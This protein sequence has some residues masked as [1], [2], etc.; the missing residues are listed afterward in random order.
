MKKFIIFL[1]VLT[2]LLVLPSPSK[3]VSQ[4]FRRIKTIPSIDK[5]VEVTSSLGW[6]EKDAQ[7]LLELTRRENKPI[8]NLL[9]S[10]I[11]A[12][13]ILNPK[14][15]LTGVPEP[16]HLPYGIGGVYPINDWD[17]I[18]QAIKQLDPQNVKLLKVG[19]QNDEKGGTLWEIP[20]PEEMNPAEEEL[21]ARY[22]AHRIVNHL[23][24]YG[25]EKVMLSDSE[26][27]QKIKK[28]F[29]PLRG[30]DVTLKF[31][32][33][34]IEEQVFAPDAS[35]ISGQFLDF[36][37]GLAEE[38]FRKIKQVL[39][40]TYSGKFVELLASALRQD[41]RYS[42]IR[43]I[44]R[45]NN[46]DLVMDKFFENYYGQELPIVFQQ[47]VEI[48]PQKIEPYPTTIMKE[49][50][51]ISIGIDA[52]GTQIKGV[53]IKDGKILAY[54]NISSW[55]FDYQQ[56]SEKA[57]A[58]G[59][60]PE[61]EKFDIQTVIDDYILK[62]IELL[63]EKAGIELNYNDD[64]VSI[65]IGW[66][67]QVR[68]GLIAAPS[69]AS[70]A[71]R[72]PLDEIRDFAHRVKIA[73]YDRWNV[74]PRAILEHDNRIYG[75]GGMVFLNR[76]QK[77]SSRDGEIFDRA[78]DVFGTDNSR[79]DINRNNR[80]LRMIGQINQI[81]FDMA[82]PEDAFNPVWE[83]AQAGLGY[84]S[85]T[86]IVNIAQ[87]YKMLG[88]REAKDV[89]ERAEE[90]DTVAR[91]VL[92]TVG[93]YL[94]MAMP[95]FLRINPDVKEIYFA[96]GPLIGISGKI[97]IDTAKK[98]LEELKLRYPELKDLKLILL[99]DGEIFDFQKLGIEP[100]DASEFVNLY[101]GAIGAGFM[102][103]D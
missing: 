88:I 39:V 43:I 32:D 78:I 7:A 22:I 103:R 69:G 89:A 3:K 86:A 1:L 13:R 50:R 72:Q 45:V 38:K 48:I 29:Q 34:T 2:N 6:D 36:L 33:G 70:L 79:A 99:S 19:F 8:A 44:Q 96:G 14:D 76:L 24:I 61:E 46:F 100:E 84:L 57:V 90:G 4:I 63:A 93:Y 85:G 9:L 66:P 49:H 40:R 51:G 98:Y 71:I 11:G 10:M 12:Y 35:I 60:E 15:V 62:L 25:A 82:P 97:I 74:D 92:E 73:I 75:L 67:G 59:R 87:R 16:D 41:E 17:K 26:L 54:K 55:R 5:I 65:G 31:S 80:M 68:D 91:R 52:G 101:I 94:A 21:S 56:R 18:F 47:E 83:V 42:H 37:D 77:T 95:E 30:V 58:E 53:L 20:L 28:F 81:V 27:Y 102:T 23:V 64:F